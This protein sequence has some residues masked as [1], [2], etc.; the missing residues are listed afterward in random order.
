MDR[1]KRKPINRRRATRMA[2]D[3]PRYPLKR[4]REEKWGKS[5]ER[6][7]KSYPQVINLLPLDPLLKAVLRL[8]STKGSAPHGCFQEYSG[9]KDVFLSALS[10]SFLPI[11]RFP[12]GLTFAP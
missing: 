6:V 12:F 2:Q 9:R 4:S 1:G 7:R 10:L 5:G 8:S 11:T 3:G